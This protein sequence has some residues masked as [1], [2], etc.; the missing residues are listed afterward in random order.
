[1][2]VSSD[3]TKAVLGLKLV[4]PTRFERAT[5]TFGEH[6]LTMFLCFVFRFNAVLFGKY[7][8]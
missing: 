8:K 6:K 3:K 2:D 5:S 1:M 4:R 7:V